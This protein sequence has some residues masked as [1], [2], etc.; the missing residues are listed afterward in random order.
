MSSNSYL[1]SKLVPKSKD[2]NERI[3]IAC[4]MMD[5]FYLISNPS[6]IRRLRVKCSL[7][8]FIQLNLCFGN[9]FRC[10]AGSKLFRVL[11]CSVVRALRFCPVSPIVPHR[12]RFLGKQ[13]V[14]GE[15]SCLLNG[16]FV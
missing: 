16:I 6:A 5:F 2:Y 14:K 4:S 11:S 3:T 13:R 1:F 9:S 7:C 15:G 10:L 12:N 8:N